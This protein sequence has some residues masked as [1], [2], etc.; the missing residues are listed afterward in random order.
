MRQ[1]SNVKRIRTKD[2]SK[3]ADTYPN[4]KILDQ[5]PNRPITSAELRLSVQC[6]PSTMLR[7]LTE[8]YNA[9]MVTRVR[10][11]IIWVW[12]KKKEVK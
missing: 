7:K 4:S 2:K 8:L 5:M 6:S 12:E 9:G 11:G 1:K 10:A 3:F